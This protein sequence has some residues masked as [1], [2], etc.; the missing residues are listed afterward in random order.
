MQKDG[1]IEDLGRKFV[2]FNSMKSLMYAD[3][4]EAI[5]KKDFLPPITVE[6]DPT[7]KCNQS[8][9]WCIVQRYFKDETVF[10]PTPVM[11]KL[12]RDLAEHGTK[13]I[14][15]VGGGEPLM[16]E[17]IPGACRYVREN[18]MECSMVTNGSLLT[19]AKCDI[20][21]DTCTYI[22]ISLDA[23][24]APTYAKLHHST[25]DTFR[26]IIGQIKYLASVN[27]GSL[28]IGTAF[29]IHP[30]NISE[31]YEAAR[32]VK[33]AGAGYMQFR[34]V[35]MR[36][37]VDKFLKENF[38][39][40][41]QELARLDELK[42]DTFTPINAFKKLE[43]HL[44]GKWTFERCRATP[45][46]AVVGATGDVYLCCERRGEVT[47]GNIKEKGFF[48]IWNSPEHHRIIESLNIDGCRK[49][50][51]LTGYNEIIENV[52]MKDKLHRNFL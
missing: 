19:E 21:A 36:G 49:L 2:P 30:E 23:G 51:A 13:G 42:S 48:E 32:L 35:Y 3:H 38:Q 7:F 9:I 33:E 6:I 47:I 31:I 18:G 44:K 27:K 20:I 28:T 14:L 17:D 40:I 16:H 22:R 41:E 43:P 5:L 29:L 4:Y 1:N 39:R 45:L 52:F 37:T 34:P 15:F 8:C 11:R 46:K 26:H 25:E 12:I 50:C 10:L 24:T